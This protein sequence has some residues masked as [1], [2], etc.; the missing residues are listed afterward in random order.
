MPRARARPH[1]CRLPVNQS[2]TPTSG[3]SGGHTRP[4]HDPAPPCRADTHSTFYLYPLFSR[5]LGP[6]QFDPTAP[7]CHAL[8]TNAYPGLA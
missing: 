5:G 8:T 6:D 3:L 2:L 1:A 7:L 4:E